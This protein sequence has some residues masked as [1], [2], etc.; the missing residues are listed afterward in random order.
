MRFTTR[1]VHHKNGKHTTKPTYAV[2]REAR[3]LM[4]VMQQRRIAEQRGILAAAKGLRTLNYPLSVAWAVLLGSERTAV[5]E[6][7][8]EQLF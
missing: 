4:W 2:S 5:N 8:R 1:T 3:A 7:L 6:L